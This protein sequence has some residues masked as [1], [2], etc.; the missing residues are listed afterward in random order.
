MNNY[1]LEG[2]VPRGGGLVATNREKKMWV[3]R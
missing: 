2:E 3:G 1:L